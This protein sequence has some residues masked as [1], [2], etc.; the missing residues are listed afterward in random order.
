V[1]GLWRRWAADSA[2]ACK[3]CCVAA[4]CGR[5]VVWQRSLP[6]RREGGSERWCM[7]ESY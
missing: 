7:C 5:E 2:G 4:Q 1:G 6:G 3:G